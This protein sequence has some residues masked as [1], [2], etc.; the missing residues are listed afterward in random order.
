VDPEDC[1]FLDTETTGLAGGGG[2]LAFLTGLARVRD[3]R[4]CVR[5]HLITRFGAEASM[6]TRLETRPR[7]TETLVTYNGKC[8]DVPLLSDRLRL[9]GMPNP[10]LALPHLDLL[11]AA[12]KGFGNRWPDCRLATAEQQLL[13]YRR[14]GDLPGR[15]APRAWLDWV[16]ERRW[17]GL[18]EVVRHNLADLVSLALLL[19]AL[20][21]RPWPPRGA[22]ESSRH[23]R[24]AA[25]RRGDAP[26]G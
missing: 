24:A 7:G 15:E 22:G 1:L 17:R 6:L 4:L 23:P 18:R 26:P 5:Q 12:R 19:P 2:T 25:S 3:G 16:R 11:H 14:R 8:F 13:G 20:G 9:H 21:A 10:L